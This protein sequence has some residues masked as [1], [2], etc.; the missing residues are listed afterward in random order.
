NN[1]GGCG[2]MCIAT[3]MCMGGQCVCPGGGSLCGNACVDLQDDPKNCG[4][5]GQ[6]CMAGG[7][8]QAGVCNNPP[9]F[10]FSGV[11]T[12]VAI[13]SLTGGGWAQ[14]FQDGYGETTPISTIEAACTQQNLLLG[15]RN[16]GAAKLT[17]AAHGPRADVLFDTGSSNTPH[18]AN[19]VGW[20]FNGNFS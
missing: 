20:Y 8:C 5:C 15:C 12:N 10:S 6:A 19:G 11:G 14:C 7:T 1:C 13:A 17:I 4:A 3:A 2:Q 16:K 9:P 18:N